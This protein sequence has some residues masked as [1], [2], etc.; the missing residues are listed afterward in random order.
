M[1]PFPARVPFVVQQLMRKKYV[2]N[3][4]PN[5]GKCLYLTFD[6]GPI[7]EIT[8]WVLDLLRKERVRATFFCVGENVVKQPRIF[9]QIKT[10]GHTVGNHSHNH[11]NGWKTT[12]SDY[13]ENYLKGKEQVGSN[14]FR[15]PYGKITRPQAQEIAVSDH[16][17]MWSVLT[18]DYS[19]NQTPQ[20]CLD[21]ALKCRNG[22]I[23]VFHDN[24][25][26]K[27]NL[28]YSLPKFIRH[29]KALGYRFATL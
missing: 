3:K 13:I 12:K 20:M 25:K 5:K 18:K 16:I 11:V 26:A 14:L 21:N 4:V 27:K 19:A 1:V 23:V 15:P 24:V 29:Y 2:W 6:D 7:P 10:D 17:I 9:E 28:Y 22:D 8:P